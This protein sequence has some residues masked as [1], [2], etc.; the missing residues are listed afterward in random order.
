MKKNK[1]GRAPSPRYAAGADLMRVLCVAMIGWYHIWQQS[2]LSPRLRLGGF[3]LDMTAPV[4][5]GYL[6]VDLMLLIS[7]F[8]CYLPYANGREDDAGAFYLKRALRILPSYWFCLA[9]MLA[10]ALLSPGFSDLPR[11]M[12]D[13]G[14]HLVFLHNL[15]PFSYTMSRLNVVL[16]TLAVEVQFYLLLPALAPVFRR[17]PLICWAAMTGLA[18]SFRHLWTLPLSD[19]TLLVNRLPNMLDV[20][21]AGMLAAHFYPKLTKMKKRRTLIAALGTLALAVGLW[22]I[23]RLVDGQAHV[24]GY[25]AVRQG[26]LLRR[27]PLAACGALCLLGGSLSFRGVRAACSNP[28]VRW[29]SSVSF[30]FYI[31]HQWLAVQLKKLR[32]PPYLAAENPNMAGEQPWQT[33][34]TLLC[35]AVALLAAA[36]VTYLIEKPCARRARAWVKRAGKQESAEIREGQEKQEGQEG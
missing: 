19:T 6:F 32:I 24:S 21:A 25:E 13:L 34:Y 14:L 7:G 33:R 5:A 1:I 30:N 4:R 27:F 20:Y 23:C 8:L 10:I 36:A 16:W 2:W 3:V 35:F 18:F 11:L 29:L 22:G 9:V 15:F 12:G 31:W 26:Q 17:R 28:A